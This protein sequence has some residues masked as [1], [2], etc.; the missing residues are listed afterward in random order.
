MLLGISR[1]HS[2]NCI[3]L[4]PFNLETRIKG[5]SGLNEDAEKVGD[6]TESLLPGLK[7][8]ARRQGVYMM[9][10]YKPLMALLGQYNSAAGKH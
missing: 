7:R 2:D 1:S 3:Q 9:E 5:A 10:T 6:D 8:G 4:Q